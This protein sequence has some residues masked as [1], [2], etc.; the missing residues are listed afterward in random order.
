MRS[1]LEVEGTQAPKAGT[2]WPSNPSLSLS[3]PSSLPY[4]HHLS[5]QITA[6]KSTF[7]SPEETGP[8]D[9]MYP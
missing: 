4:H 7:V 1:D 3:F 6:D 5:P 9:K 2:K 8:P